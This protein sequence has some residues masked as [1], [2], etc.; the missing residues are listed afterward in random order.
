MAIRKH[1]YPP[2][3]KPQPAKVHTHFISPTATAHGPLT[4]VHMLPHP[5]TCIFLAQTLAVL[6]VQGIGRPQRYICATVILES[7]SFFDLTVNVT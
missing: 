3:K 1:M 5:A 4:P 7:L 2:S 6:Q